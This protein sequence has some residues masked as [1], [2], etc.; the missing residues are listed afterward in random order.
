M[1]RPTI[2][3]QSTPRPDALAGITPGTGVDPIPAIP[4]SQ[5]SGDLA[6]LFADIR[7]TLQVP[8]VNLVW[9][10]LA[11]IDGALPWTWALVK[12]LYG[13]VAFNAAA[14]TLHEPANIT[15]LVH[16]I[17]AYVFDAS[18]I[19]RADRAEMTRLIDDY[20][21]ANARAVLAL[22]GA[23]QILLDATPGI[24][25]AG[26][27]TGASVAGRFNPL[28]AR[29]PA[30]VPAIGRSRP[31]PAMDQLPQPM[32]ELIDALNRLGLA[33]PTPIVASLYRHLAYWPGFLAMVWV[34]LEPLDR[35]D[36]LKSAVA[37]ILQH[38]KHTVEKWSIPA[39]AHPILGAAEKQQLERSLNAFTEVAIS[40]MVVLGAAM[41]TLVSVGD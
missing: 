15:Q 10:H 6:T 5:A 17:D 11:T 30:R 22:L 25:A 23:R 4:E 24:E 7:Q 36:Q 14:D 18:G 13:S 35:N 19:T 37:R 27:G 40:R 28:D 32:L 33:R 12:P 38:A 31:L 26:P 34:A 20:G 21:R 29:M 1:T 16:P 3:H 41:R 8:F 2:D 9:R 39:P